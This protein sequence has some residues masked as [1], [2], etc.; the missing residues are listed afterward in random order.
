MKYSIIVP[1]YNVEKYIEACMTSLINQTFRDYEIIV[2][3]DESP[4]GSMDIVERFRQQDPDRI[5]VVHQKNTRQGGARNHGVELARGE[6]LIF[7]DGDDYVSTDMLQTVE[8]RLQENPCDILVYSFRSVTEDHEP[9]WDDD[10]ILLPPG[11]YRP[12][13]DRNVVL[14]P[15]GPVNKAYRRD[16]YVRTGFR[17]PEKLWYEDTVTRFLYAS[18]DSIFVTDDPLYYY[19]RRENSSM[20]QKTS[21]KMLDILKV[22]DLTCR[23]FREAGLYEDFREPLEIS[24]IYSLLCVENIINTRDPA[25]PMQSA[26]ADYIAEQ[27][28]S[29][30]SNPWASPEL[31]KSLDCLTAHQFRRYHICF[32]QKNQ[33]KDRLLRIPLIRRLNEFRKNR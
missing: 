22:S 26:I 33:M 16:F 24:L 15:C 5:R 4:D 27:F 19:V 1:V 12:A 18:A 30:G 11:L 8:N 14:L 13:R 10:E 31:V 6:Y 20:T 23:Y 3:D 32:L 21:E 29:Y 25:N 17:F 28:G 7:V 9:L 2:V